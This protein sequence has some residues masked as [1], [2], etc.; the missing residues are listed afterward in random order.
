M[1]VTEAKSYQRLKK[2]AL[3]E[4][5]GRNSIVVEMSFERIYR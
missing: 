2:D 5:L 1:P 4:V 3:L